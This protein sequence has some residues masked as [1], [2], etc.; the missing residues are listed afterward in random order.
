VKVQKIPVKKPNWQYSPTGM[1]AS[2]CIYREGQGD[3]KWMKEKDTKY[4]ARSLQE[5]QTAT[6]QH[7]M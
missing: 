2:R 1:N 3:K 6:Q 7:R 4:L 5:T